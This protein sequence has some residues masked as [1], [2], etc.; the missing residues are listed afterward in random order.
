MLNVFWVQMQLRRT[1]LEM[2][3][4]S[5]GAVS[6]RIPLRERPCARLAHCPDLLPLWTIQAGQ[7]EKNAYQ[8]NS[9]R[10]VA[11]GDGRRPAPLYLLVKAY[12]RYSF[13]INDPRAAWGEFPTS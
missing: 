6:R 12:E 8:C 13:G 10:R 11:H 2:V 4:F 7:H 1:L 9:G 3:N 5:N